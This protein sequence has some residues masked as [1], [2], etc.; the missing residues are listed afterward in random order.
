MPSYS[1]VYSGAFIQYT[2]STPNTAFDVPEGFT[3]VIRQISAAQDIGGW[4]L[5]VFIQ[6]SEAAPG[7]VIAELGQVG[8]VN[9]AAQEG[10]WVCPGGGI[11]SVS[12]TELGSDVAIYVGGYL[13]RNTLT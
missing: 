7:L 11:I 13:L 6:D 2:P 9:Y 4:I 12:L 3:A 8:S 1:P 10:R 5:N